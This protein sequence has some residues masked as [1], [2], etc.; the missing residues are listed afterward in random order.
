MDIKKFSDYKLNEGLVHQSSL[1]QI[2]AIQ[3]EIDKIG[4]IG[5]KFTDDVQD[6]YD[7]HNDTDV[8]DTEYLY[9]M[10]NN[11][12]HAGKN[13]DI[14]KFTAI[15]GQGNLGEYIGD[16]TDQEYAN[17]YYQY[18]PLTTKVDTIESFDMQFWFNGSSWAKVPKDGSKPTGLSAQR[19]TLNKT[20]SNKDK[21]KKSRVIKESVNYNNSFQ[22]KKFSEFND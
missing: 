9:D 15:F 3:K 20:T 16:L 7:N 10:S 14:T 13:A 22:I 17:N 18:N 12:Q 5:R 4:D 11:I 19:S 6:F 21:K 2:L 8:I 1:D